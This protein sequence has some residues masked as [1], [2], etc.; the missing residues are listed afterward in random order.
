MMS[1][2]KK[3]QNLEKDKILTE[4]EE[5]IKKKIEDKAANNKS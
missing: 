5:N 1:N 3:S 4:F 2:V